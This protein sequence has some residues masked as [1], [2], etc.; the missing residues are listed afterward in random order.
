MFP[1]EYLEVDYAIRR[2]DPEHQWYVNYAIVCGF[3]YM[4]CMPFASFMA[5]R[6]KKDLIKKVQDAAVTDGGK[7]SL[8][9]SI[10]IN[11]LKRK[12][13]L[14]GGLIPLYKWEQFIFI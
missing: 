11:R 2:S 4:V 1:N 5:L 9:N 7:K 3:I 10:L 14:L 8:E 12:D 6:K 13:A